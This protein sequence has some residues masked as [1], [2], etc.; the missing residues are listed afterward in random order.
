MT[1]VQGTPCIIG[2]HRA[3]GLLTT[4]TVDVTEIFP[5]EIVIEDVPAKRKND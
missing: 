5:H 3:E 2:M 1:L 4:D